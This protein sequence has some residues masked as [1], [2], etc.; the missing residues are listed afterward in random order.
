MIQTGIYQHFKGGRYRV[1]GT[2]QHAETG[3][4]LVI[5]EPLYH[6]PMKYWARP[7]ARFMEQVVHPDG[8]SVNR[9][10]FISG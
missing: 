6:C 8:S 4:L 10:E 3:E 2:A 1:I 7:L 5:Y 9:F